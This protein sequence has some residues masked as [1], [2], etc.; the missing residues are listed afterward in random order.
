MQHKGSTAP[1]CQNSFEVY[2][3]PACLDAQQAR[4]AGPVALAMLLEQTRARTLGL[5]HD[6]MTTLGPGCEVPHE[7]GLNPPLWEAGH[8]A[9]FQEWW[10]AR[11]KELLL[12]LAC[13][14]NHTRGPSLF[15]NADAYFNSSEIA[16]ADRWA[17][18]LRQADEILDYMQ[19]TLVQTQSMLT[20]LDAEG[21]AGENS[22]YFFRLA[23]FHEQMHNEAAVYMAQRLNIPLQAHH[24]GQSLQPMPASPPVLQVSAH[25]HSLGYRGPG[26]AFDNELPGRPV[27]LGDF[28]IDAS[29]VSWAKYLEFANSTSH[30][31]PTCIRGGNGGFEILRFGQWLPLCLHWPAMHLSLQ[32]AQA[33][34]AW[35]GRTLP[36]EAQWEYCASHLPAFEWGQVWEW[37]AS[38]FAPFEGFVPHPYQDY[39]APWFDG[40][41]VLKGA[42]FATA[43]HMRHIKYRNYFTPDRTD[44]FAGFRTCSL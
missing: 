13:N 25:H 4:Q 33:Y 38:P 27:A 16:H 32:D 34:C 14:P 7:L 20:E 21:Q 31:L 8:I 43:P 40:R 10:V 28:D 19:A 12:G 30:P 37:T 11:N 2:T 26:F 24:I 35:A 23:L 42:S 44:L 9:W 29:P 39:S 17:L 41:P 36:T 6:Y 1:D 3:T 18:A 22:L 5:L 15:G